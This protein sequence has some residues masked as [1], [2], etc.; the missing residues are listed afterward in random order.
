MATGIQTGLR[1]GAR[2][3]LAEEK[4]QSLP[5][6]IVSF[7]R[8]LSSK[9]VIAAIGAAFLVLVLLTGLGVRNHHTGHVDLYPAKL[10]A[11]ELPEVSRALVDAGIEH[12]ITPNSDGIL[13]PRQDRARART[14]L[15][16]LELPRHRVLNADEAKSDLVR[17]AAE[18]RQLAQRVLEGE[19]TLALREFEGVRD[20]R[21]KLA[22]PEQR[23]FN[24][25]EL[26]TASVVLALKPG[27]TLSK[28]SIKALSSLVAFSVPGLVT[29]RVVI[30][31]TTGRELTPERN[32]PDELVQGA[33]FEVLASEEARRQKQ[34]EETLGAIYPGRVKA[35]VALEM[36]FSQAEK[37]L[38]TPGSVEDRGMVRDSMQLV[39]E[40][41]E[42]SGGSKDSKGSKNY[43]S[44]KE[45]VN[46]K[47]M[48]NYYASLVKHARVER[49]TA[50]VL[51][52]GISDKEAADLEKTV[53]S[54]LGIQTERGDYVNVNNTPWDH[55]LSADATQELP[56]LAHSESSDVPAGSGWLIFLLGQGVV[57]CV[58]AGGIFLYSRQRSQAAAV[59][60]SPGRSPFSGIVDHR[61]NM[62]GETLLESPDTTVQRSEML[63][64]IVKERPSQV[65]DLLRST[66]LS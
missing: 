40:A 51:A 12:E 7:L 35:V 48:E 34:V 17:G 39:T 66:W 63:A 8:G 41:L 58:V 24:N 46:Y 52:D 32:N 57:L 38:Y 53:Q 11:H 56:F 2:N 65:A 1:R 36:D 13:L 50:A 5:T 20:A 43:D 23:F 59:I 31:D 30:V 64:G 19:I 27:A 4:P 44:R 9:V 26:S 60:A 6:R 18:K 55:S 54:I 37:R 29:E 47:Y 22:V 61:Q 15:A 45:S 25:G 62:R 33:H 42:G 10:L 28:K 14:L 3:T 49:I 21:V 16:T